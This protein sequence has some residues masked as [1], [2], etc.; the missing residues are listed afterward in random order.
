MNIVINPVFQ[1][2]REVQSF[3]K[4]N[5]RYPDLVLCGPE[6][7]LNLR[8]AIPLQILFNENYDEIFENIKFKVDRNTIGFHAVLEKKPITQHD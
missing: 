1:F 6:S 3:F 5:G 7:Y 8:S 4:R 2:R